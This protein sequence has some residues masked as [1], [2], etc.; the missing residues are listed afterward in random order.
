M[1]T[2]E[3]MEL[4]LEDV[5]RIEI[6]VR[7]IVQLRP[8]VCDRVAASKFER[9]QAIDFVLV[10]HMVSNSILGVHATL[11]GLRYIA[12]TFRVTRMT[13]RRCT[14]MEHRSRRSAK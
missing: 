6:A 2:D 9:D 10:P 13:D 4:V 7:S 1:R 11:F 5:L 8:E 12:N 3:R 14:N